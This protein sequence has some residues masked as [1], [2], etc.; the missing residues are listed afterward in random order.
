MA[1]TNVARLKRFS[2]VSSDCV[3][4]AAQN[5]GI[6][7]S[8]EVSSA[9][10]EDVSFRV[11]H[12][13]DVSEHSFTGS[14]MVYCSNYCILSLQAACQFMQH[15]KRKRLTTDDFDKALKWSRVE[16]CKAYTYVYS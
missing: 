5:L 14:F 15:A 10:V 7:T 9:L 8:N 16:V 2:K 11:R 4:Q 6:Q 12:I 13:T 1:T 3:F